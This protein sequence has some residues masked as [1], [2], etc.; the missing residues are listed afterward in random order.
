M[1]TSKRFCILIASCLCA[2]Q[3]SAQT[4]TGLRI[5]EIMAANVEEVLDPTFNYG[6]W[7]EVYNST[8]RAENLK[9]MWLSDDAENLKKFPILYDTP[10]PAHGFA[11]LWFGHYELLT[12]KQIDLKLDCDGGKIRPYLTAAMPA[13]MMAPESGDIRIRPRLARRTTAPPSANCASR[14]L[15]WM[16]P[17]RCSRV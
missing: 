10:V 7:I 3:I 2:A 17:A 6:G 15:R 5:N 1:K 4:L 9:G 13:S 16:C 8:T 11:V 12:P 14:L